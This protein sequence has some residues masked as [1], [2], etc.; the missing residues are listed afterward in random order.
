ML[1]WKIDVQRAIL[2]IN[3]KGDKHRIVPLT[4]NTKEAIDNWLKVR[5]HE[6]EYLLVSSKSNYITTRAIQHIFKKY[7]IQLGIEITPHSLRHTYYKQLAQQG[8]DISIY[9]RTCGTK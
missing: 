5:D 7:S 3:G 4:E 8:A 2:R 9:R 6:S 1:N